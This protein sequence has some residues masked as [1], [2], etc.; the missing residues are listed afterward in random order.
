MNNNEISTHP[1]NTEA[2]AETQS[3]EHVD[4]PPKLVDLALIAPEDSSPHSFASAYR[5]QSSIKISEIKQDGSYQFR[6]ATNLANVETMK[7][8]ILDGIKFRTPIRLLAGMWQSLDI[9]DGHHRVEAYKSLGRTEIPID[10]VEIIETRSC[11]AETIMPMAANTTHGLKNTYADFYKMLSH[12]AEKKHPREFL[13]N[14]F[15]LDIPTIA[16]NIDASQSVLEAAHNKYKGPKDAPHPTLSQ[17]LKAKRDAAIIE[18]YTDEG[19]SANAIATKFN[20]K[21]HKTVRRVIDDRE[22]ER[23]ES[24][25]RWEERRAAEEAEWVERA[26]KH[27]YGAH[28]VE[29]FKQMADLLENYDDNGRYIGNDEP[30]APPVVLPMADTSDR[31]ATRADPDE[32]RA[33]HMANV[34]RIEAKAASAPAPFDIKSLGW[35]DGPGS[36][37][38]AVRIADMDAEKLQE[39]WK[40]NQVVKKRA[41]RKH[42][43]LLA[44]AA[45]LGISLEG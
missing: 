26:A 19:M 42:A 23:A 31:S 40:Q 13:K 21:S 6:A 9:I 34:D 35:G 4:A 29:R 36:N 37:A 8:L 33:K 24:E 25:N 12:I 2:T 32:V 14:D 18:A 3:A 39:A 20:I 45:K 15:E 38:K 1:M 7:G 22:A 43:E 28:E 5:K 17:Q 41:D 10:Q 11:A 44:A 30:T 27:G 16:L